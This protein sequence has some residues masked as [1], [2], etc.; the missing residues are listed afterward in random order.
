MEVQTTSILFHSSFLRV[1]RKD[2]M[3]CQA[4]SAKGARGPSSLH[5]SHLMAAE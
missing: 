1:D 3:D 5:S 4:G 2:G